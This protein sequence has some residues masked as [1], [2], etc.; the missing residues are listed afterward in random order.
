MLIQ[1]ALQVPR[2][3]S[4]MKTPH[5]RDQLAR[6]VEMFMPVKTIVHIG[7]N[8]VCLSLVQIHV[9]CAEHSLSAS[10]RESRAEGWGNRP[11]SGEF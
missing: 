4:L 1:R 3:W 11:N 7:T 8:P 5:F 10:E 2:V 9:V 6:R